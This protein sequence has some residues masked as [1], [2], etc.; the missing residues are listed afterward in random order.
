M[1]EIKEELTSKEK[2]IRK[3]G[4]LVGYG[5]ALQETREIL[6]GLVEDVEETL[7]Q[8]K[9][10]LETNEKTDETKKDEEKGE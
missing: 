5:T 3:E 7:K 9:E 2:A 4:F 10:Q 1:E 8:I 6:S